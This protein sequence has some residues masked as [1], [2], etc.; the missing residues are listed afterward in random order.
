MLLGTSGLCCSSSSN[1]SSKSFFTINLPVTGSTPFSNESSTLGR[2][3][4]N[5]D[6]LYKQSKPKN[7][8]NPTNTYF[9]SFVEWIASLFSFIFGT[10]QNPIF[11]ENQRVKPL[12]TE[13]IH[14]WRTKQK[15]ELNF[16]YGFF[17]RSTFWGRLY[18]RVVRIEMGI[19][20]KIWG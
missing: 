13:Q 2:A 15:G 8:T 11:Q 1:N 14:Y 7:S 17:W 12:V 6:P 19:M 9:N 16:F 3:G 20:H 5:N 4:A 10:K 18:V